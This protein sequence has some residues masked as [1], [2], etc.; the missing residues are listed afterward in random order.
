[1]TSRHAMRDGGQDLVDH[2]EEHAS[3]ARTRRGSSSPAAPCRSR[4]PVPIASRERA[5]QRAEH[6]RHEQQEAEDRMSPTDSSRLRRKY[7]KPLVFSGGTSQIWSRPSFSSASAVVAPT[8]SV[9]T[10]TSVAMM[11]AP[12]RLAFCT[13]AWIACAPVR[14]EQSRTCVVDLAARRLLTEEQPGDGDGQDQDRRQR[15]HRVER[16]RR[17]LARRAVIDPFHDGFAA[18]A[19]MLCACQRFTA[20]PAHATCTAS[21]ATTALTG[22]VIRRTPR[23][24]RAVHAELK[25]RSARPHPDAVE[26]EHWRV[27]RERSQPRRRAEQ[28]VQPAQRA[29]DGAATR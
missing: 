20:S 10:P 4:P 17:A 16:E 7:Q 25:Q 11:P 18:R 9:T 5:E 19:P 15:E 23:Q 21:G 26:R 28:A 1:M 13:I 24:L 3:R 27:H 12:G 8:N 14:P 6:Q 22:K 2:R 29:A